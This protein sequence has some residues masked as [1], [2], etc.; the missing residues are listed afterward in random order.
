MI[1]R[2]NE[3]DYG[4]I[5]DC[6]MFCGF[7][8]L[9]IMFFLPLVCRPGSAFGR[10][11]ANQSL[12]LLILSVIAEI[13]FRVLDAILK[14]IGLNVLATIVSIISIVVYLPLLVL[15]LIGLV[16]AFRG[17]AIELPVVGKIH[18]LK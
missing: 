4:D 9:F 16:S 11:H 14:S 17:T 8:Y 5:V 6:K 10:F 18:L 13:I 3:F 15:F 7:S 1:D 12:V 2:T